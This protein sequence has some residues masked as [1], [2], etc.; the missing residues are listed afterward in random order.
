MCLAYFICYCAT[1][2]AGTCGLVRCHRVTSITVAATAF[3]LDGT[4]KNDLPWVDIVDLSRYV[5]TIS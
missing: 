5:I 2:K 1:C 3:E 4:E